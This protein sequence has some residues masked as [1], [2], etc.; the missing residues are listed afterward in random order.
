[1]GHP[2]RRS[3]S[4]FKFPRSDLKW[5]ISNYLTNASRKVN[6]KLGLSYSTTKELNCI[7]DTLPGQPAFQSQNLIVG[8]ET[9]TFYFQDVMQCIQALYGDPEFARELVFAPERHYLDP[10]QRCRIYNEMHTGDWWWA[11]QVHTCIF[12]SLS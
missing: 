5:Q 10:E 3:R 4:Y 2:Q 8:E 7:I 12:S 9:L 11:V 1:M 6:S